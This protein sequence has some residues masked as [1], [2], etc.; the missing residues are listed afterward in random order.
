MKELILLSYLDLAN[1]MIGLFKSETPDNVTDLIDGN[2][3][4]LPSV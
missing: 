3:W 4:L 1:N 2:N